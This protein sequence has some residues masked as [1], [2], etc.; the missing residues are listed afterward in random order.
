V[1]RTPTTIV[2]DAAGGE[3]TR[4]VGAPSKAA[5]IAALGRAIP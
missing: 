3:V 1:V 4:G 5:A 2:L